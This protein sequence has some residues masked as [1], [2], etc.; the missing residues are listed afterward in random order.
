[1][2]AQESY[3]NDPISE[4]TLGSK[5]SSHKTKSADGLFSNWSCHERMRAPCRGTHRPTQE[6]R[7]RTEAEND[8]GYSP[9]EFTPSTAIPDT[10]AN[11]ATTLLPEEMRVNSSDGALNC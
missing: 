2:G 9:S 3:P 5:H 8:H 4:K 7:P 11:I 10:P 1:M 6:W